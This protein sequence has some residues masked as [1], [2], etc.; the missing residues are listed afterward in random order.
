LSQLILL[1]QIQRVP[2]TR[3]KE[4]NQKDNMKYQDR[5]HLFFAR[6]P[7]IWVYNQ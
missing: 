7:L 1:L 4:R 2:L 3:V 5:L 6:H